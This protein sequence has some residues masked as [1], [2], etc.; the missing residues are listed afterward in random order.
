MCSRHTL[1]LV[2]HG[3][4]GKNSAAK[5][6]MN[7]IFNRFEELTNKKNIK[8]IQNKVKTLLEL[9]PNPWGNPTL[10]KILNNE[11][12]TDDEGL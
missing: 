5:L 6:H 10:N 12:L 3:D 4:W 7:V 11:P 2:L 1:H 9:F 8:G